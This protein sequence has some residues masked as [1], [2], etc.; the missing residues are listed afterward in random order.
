MMKEKKTFQPLTS[1]NICEIY[2]LLR[3]SHLVSFS[4]TSDAE[5]KIESLVSSINSAYFGAAVYPSLEEKSVAYLWFLIK[6]HPFTD[7]NKRTACL[8]FSVIC[9][10]NNLQ[11]NYRDFSLDE[12]AVFIEQYKPDGHQTAI[13]LLAGMLFGAKN[14]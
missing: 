12:L 3:S 2:N 4:L 6:N 13:R 1:K 8:A 11:P 5:H 10:I 9:S 7:G 14:I